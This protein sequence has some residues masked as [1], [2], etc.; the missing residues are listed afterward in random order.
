MILKGFIM[1]L[2]EMW[3]TLVDQGIATEQELQL[4]TNINGYNEEAMLSV[5]YARTA[6]NSFEQLEEEY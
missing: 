2:Q 1:T 4:V 3:E 6:L 5:L